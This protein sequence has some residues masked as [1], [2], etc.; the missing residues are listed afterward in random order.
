ML[1]FCNRSAIAVSIFGCTC[2]L[3]GERCG[4]INLAFALLG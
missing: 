4:Y 2:T 3:S 1:K